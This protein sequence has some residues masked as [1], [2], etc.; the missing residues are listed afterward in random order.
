[1]INLKKYY[2]LEAVV[3]IVSLILFF[4]FIFLNQNKDIQELYN[5]KS[6]LIY[7]GF[8]VPIIHIIFIVI[9]MSLNKHYISNKYDSMMSYF[10]VL[11]LA[12]VLVVL[13]YTIKDEWFLNVHILF[14]LFI[15]LAYI[16]FVS[17]GIALSKKDNAKLKRIKN[18][19][20]NKT[21]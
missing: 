15:P 7:F 2:I 8:I 12:S 5:Y 19:K 6:A 3:F 16:F 9:K 11:F 17:L 13:N 21:N 14:W 18:I 1:M 10:I 20:I 4:I